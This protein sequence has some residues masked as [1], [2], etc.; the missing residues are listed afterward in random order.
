[1]K[2]IEDYEWRVLPGR[3]VAHA[4]ED[5]RSTC[6][7]SQK[8]TNAQLTLPNHKT[9]KCEQCLITIVSGVDIWA[10]KFFVAHVRPETRQRRRKAWRAYLQEVRAEHKTA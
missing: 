3:K 1:M 4:I 2:K 10:D 7:H 5:G 8:Y 9:K 6:G